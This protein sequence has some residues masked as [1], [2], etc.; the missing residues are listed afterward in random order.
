VGVRKTEDGRLGPID[1]AEP[2]SAGEVASKSPKPGLRRFLKLGIARL[3]PMSERRHCCLL[4]MA[5]GA[6]SDGRT[7]PSCRS[8]CASLER[9][10]LCRTDGPVKTAAVFS[11]SKLVGELCPKL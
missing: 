6:I 1:W 9:T 4:L 3:I 11:T 10:G 8:Y 7:S 2:C 5:Q